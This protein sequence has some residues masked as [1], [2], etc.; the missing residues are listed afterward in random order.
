MT[1]KGEEVERPEQIIRKVS[2]SPTPIDDKTGT[3]TLP[4]P[5]VVQDIFED[6][7]RA[8]TEALEREDLELG[9]VH[10]KHEKISANMNGFKSDDGWTVKVSFQKRLN[11]DEGD[12]LFHFAH[13][14][15][16]NNKLLSKDQRARGVGLEQALQIRAKLF[17]ERFELPTDFSSE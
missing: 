14:S 4:L 5:V 11:K 8:Y 3:S 10:W 12:P 7:E 13:S 1:E 2:T 16:P 15:F 17:P 6:R 9:K